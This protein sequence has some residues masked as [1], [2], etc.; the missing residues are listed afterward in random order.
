MNFD[1]RY[2]LRRL[3]RARGFTL[4]ASL[5]IALGVGANTAIF[6]LVNAILLRPPVAVA[7]P[8]RLVGVFT[9]DYSGPAFGSSSYPDV[10]EFNKQSTDVF[11]GV[12]AFSPRPAA[13]GSDDNLERVAV[14]VV[15]DNYFQVLGSKLVAGRAFGPE[16]RVVGGE[17]VVVISHAL[18]QRRFAGDPAIVG[19][20]IRM[21]AREF[22]I[23]GVAPEGFA[24]SLRGPVSDVWIP[25]AIGS[26][27]GM[28]DSFTSR[29]DRSAFVYA[30]LRD[31]VTM[32]QAKARMAVV[33]RGMFGA[34]PQAWRDISKQGRRI[35]LIPE[36]AT[37]IPPQVRGPALGF[38]ALLMGTVALVLL[39]CCA[40]VAGLLL[41]RATG[42]LKEV[43]IRISLGASRGRVI[44][45]MLTESVLLALLGG[46]VGTMSAVWAG[47]ALMALGTP[48]QIPVPISLDLSPDY[49]VMWFTLAIT[50]VTGVVFGL[51]PAL[52]A[53]RADVVS[54]L[55]SDTPSMQ[56]GGRRFSLQGALVVG[57]VALSMLLLVGALLFL[58]TLSA[59]SSID[60]GFRVDNML[61]LDVA[62]RPG[63]E[64]G[65]NPQQVAIEARD[66]I[67]AIPGVTNVSWASSI[68]L[69]LDVNRRGLAVQGYRP[70]EGE[71]MEFHYSVVGPRYFETMEVPL[72]RGRGFT[73]AD[74]PGAPLVAVVNEAFAKKFWGDADPIGKRISTN[75]DAGPWLEVVGLARDGKYVTISESA[76]PYVFYPQLQSPDG[77]TL[78]VRTASDPKRLLAAVRREM[79]IVAPT[80]MI[81]R[82]RT[83]DEHMGASLLPQRIA[84]TLLASFGVV[85]LLLAAVGLYGVV[86][87]AVAQRTREIGIRVAL[88]AQRGEVLGLMLRQGMMLASIGLLV[89]LP[90]SFAVGKLISGF[91]L[92]SGVADPI[93]F[94]GAAGSLVLVTLVASFVPARRASRVDPMVALRS[95]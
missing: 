88:G 94:L 62:P 4:A 69:G 85:A 9:S 83:L 12:M 71:D 33:A 24:G 26:Y 79:G 92:G 48:A 80:W 28:G 90:L 23:I 95:Q 44:R 10:D 57:Q 66:R 54:A 59:A 63:E 34:Y 6:S 58:R 49:R 73:D 36:R 11:S 22:T 75:G 30:R 27:V 21:N 25:A 50:L 37:R 84:A 64:G 74:R 5:T 3:I 52:R 47:R 91:L 8:D 7:A 65:A 40:N 70:R 81:E 1:F 41:A 93:V 56:L 18:W 60:P 2:A 42:R 53:S 72:A 86:A 76:R 67:A 32:D 29:G 78:V 14:E 87:F 77:V 35:T 82:P 13:I 15:T 16:Q 17:P 20:P 55:K 38:V 89:G 31:G 39:V 45:Q 61:L 19:K 51:A 43:G 46:V 68:P